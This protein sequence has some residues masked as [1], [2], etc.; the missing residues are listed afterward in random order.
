MESRSLHLERQ[1]DV[2]LNGVANNTTDAKYWPLRV[3]LITIYSCVLLGGSVSIGLVICVLKSNIRSVTTTAVLNLIVVHIIFLLTVPFR[4]HYYVTDTWDLGPFFCKLVS[5]MIHAHMY[6]AFVFYVAILVV[7]Y[8]SFYLK[9]DKVEFYRKL[10]ALWASA[11]VW[12]IMLVIVLPIYIT[13]YGNSGNYTSSQCFRF[14]SEL[15]ETYVVVLNYVIIIIVVLVASGL[16]GFQMYIFW[17]I[18]RRYRSECSSYQEFWA[19]VKSFAFVMVMFV[20]FV[21]YHVFRIY[22]LVKQNNED[23][24]MDLHWQ[25][26][27]FLALTA[28]S[29][30]D[31]LTFAGKASCIA[32]N[33]ACSKLKSFL[34]CC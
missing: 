24:K 32:C 23:E 31:L 27:V 26:E 10:H 22:Y 21:P 29:C 1:M 9:R 16:K 14:E 17:K 6:I 3:A 4:I 11:G 19:Q 20:C 5:A 13:K 34:P 15:K 7:R 33:S 25:N 8:R 30:F 18:L 12:G 2:S 28:L